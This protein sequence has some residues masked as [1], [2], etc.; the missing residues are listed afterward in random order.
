M[1]PGDDTQLLASY[2]ADYTE[3]RNLKI[4]LSFTQNETQAY[5]ELVNPRESTDTDRY[6]CSF[7]VSRLGSAKGK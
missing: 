5:T 4:P 1:F 3:S 2:R 6:Y 7:P